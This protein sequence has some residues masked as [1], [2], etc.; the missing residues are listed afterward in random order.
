V[1]ITAGQEETSRCQAWRVNKEERVFKLEVRR[2]SRRERGENVRYKGVGIG[3]SGE[4]H[5]PLS[6]WSVTHRPR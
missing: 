6:A 2:R 4:T 3:V 1:T 5:R